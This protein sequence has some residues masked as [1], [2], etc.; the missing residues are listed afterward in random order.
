MLDRELH[1]LKVVPGRYEP[2]LLLDAAVRLNTSVSSLVA[3]ILV[4]ALQES[5][6]GVAWSSCIVVE[7]SGK[8]F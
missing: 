6:T 4:D 2:A 5:E 1:I 8:M 7:S 3:R